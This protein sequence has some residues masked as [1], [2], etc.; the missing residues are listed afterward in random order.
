MKL[1]LLLSAAMMLLSATVSADSETQLRGSATVDNSGDD[2]SFSSEDIPTED[3]YRSSDPFDDGMKEGKRAANKLWKNMGDDCSNAFDFASEANKK[4]RK[5]GW[6]SNGRNWRERAHNK[7]ARAGMEQVVKKKEKQCLHNNPD[8]C[9]SLGETAAVMISYEYCG[10]GASY[11]HTNYKR[12]CRS[13]AI[14]QCKGSVFDEVKSTCGS[15][16]TSTL[17]TL[18]GKC[19]RQ[20]DSLLGI[21]DKVIIEK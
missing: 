10:M 14:S 13:V 7:G 17:S 4:S 2:E 18:Q 5:K 16:D 3:I 9:I 19:R 15:P 6:N 12:E 8:E 1:H 21:N 20:V 11:S